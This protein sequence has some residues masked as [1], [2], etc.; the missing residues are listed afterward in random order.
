MVGVAGNAH[1]VVEV[2]TEAG[3]K[4]LRGI[5][6]AF[7]GE[8]FGAFAEIGIEN[9]LQTDLP[10]A[11]EFLSLVLGDGIHVGFQQREKLVEVVERIAIESAGKR[12]GI[13]G[14]DTVSLQC[15]EYILGRATL[16]KLAVAVIADNLNGTLHIGFVF[17][18]R[19][20]QVVGLTCSLENLS[21]EEGEGREVPA[22]A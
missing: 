4:R 11:R 12:H 7:V 16:C 1:V 17:Y 3:S 2:Q 19:L 21:L 20:A 10:L 6:L 22:G 13:F 14:A 9:T 8:G 18:K 15:G 5:G